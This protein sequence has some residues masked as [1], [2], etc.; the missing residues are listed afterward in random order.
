MNIV[1]RVVIAASFACAAHL[2]A[3]AD[4]TITRATELRADRY[5]DAPS[6]RL[7]ETGTRVEIVGTEAGW[8]QVRVAG[9]PGW[10]RASGVSGEGAT[11]SAASRVEG[12]RSAYGNIVV[13]AGV[14]GIPK[15]S[16]HALVIAVDSVTSGARTQRWPGVE[17][18]VEAAVQIAR[19]IAVPA[20]NVDVVHGDFDAIQAA[21]ARLDERVLPGD[22]V[23]LV[24]AGPGTDVGTDASG[25]SCVNSWV[26]SDGR[27]LTPQA[28]ATHLAPALANA[29]R[30]LVL[31]DAAYAGAGDAKDGPP[32]RTIVLE[33]R[34]RPRCTEG[35]P[36][37]FALEA[38]TR[39][40]ARVVQLEAIGPRQGVEQPHAG[41]VFMQ[42]VTDCFLGDA[43]D[44]DRSGAISIGEIARCANSTGSGGVLAS[45][46]GD[47]AYS[48]SFAVR[49][50]G[51]R[52]PV[53]PAADSARKA[54][55]EVHAQRDAR[56]RVELVA[57]QPVLAIGRDQL[58]LKLSS[59]R[60]GFAYLVL[61]G[62][63]GHS[64]YLLF[65]NDLDR[66][67]RIAAGQ[68]LQL[69]R[70]QW[71]VTSQGPPG[72]DVVLAIVSEA[73]R[74]LASFGAKE[75]PFSASLTDAAG[76]ARLADLL[77][78]SGRADNA[79]CAAGARRNLAVVRVCSDA[80]GSALLEI[81]E[82]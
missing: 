73:E 23:L 70:P 40:K 21:F 19:R 74:D 24:F 37:G 61:L 53:A 39:E 11:A 68:T 44:S 2:A 18:D 63:D 25:P 82:R 22:Q 4:G 69:P 7:L 50:E 64:F 80:Y 35:R 32:R 16:R 34:G 66:D 71:A 1:F 65:P 36:P 76:R 55:D 38:I 27:T 15:P 59:D 67:N 79:E 48:P 13:A 75:G 77:G 51:D 81:T 31:S 30:V 57:S 6:L 28:V 20:A 47:A 8:V 12:G 42:V 17:H 54:I 5:V 9:K 29:S 46:S 72:K 3:A 49:A 26:T 41:G 43:T 45:V 60:A 14:R 78:R 10:V 58:E 33:S 52:A 56:I 62:S